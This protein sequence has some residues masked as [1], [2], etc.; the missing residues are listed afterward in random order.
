LSKPKR[1]PE[2]H[3]LV[4]DWEQGLLRPVEI[5]LGELPDAGTVALDFKDRGVVI[6][7]AMH[8]VAAD[9]RL[10]LGFRLPGAPRR[11]GE[12]AHDRDAP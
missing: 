12:A 10:L 4:R 2:L 6:T 1:E 3:G 7:E 11:H 9:I 5:R 8:R